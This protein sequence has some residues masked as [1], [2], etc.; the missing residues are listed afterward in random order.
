MYGYLSWVAMVHGLRSMPG[1]ARCSVN[2]ISLLPSAA[3]GELANKSMSMFSTDTDFLK[4]LLADWVWVS[5]CERSS[6]GISAEE[7]AHL[8]VKL[9]SLIPQDDNQV[10][11][12]EGREGG[13]KERGRGGERERG[14]MGRWKEGL[15][16]GRD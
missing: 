15:R 5:C 2:L 6:G 7:K 14:K 4:R 9:A 12:D 11:S 1:A 3:L 13:E 10:R 8:R 16:E